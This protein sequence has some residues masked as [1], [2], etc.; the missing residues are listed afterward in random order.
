MAKKAKKVK[1]KGKSNH[2]KY[3]KVKNSIYDMVSSGELKIGDKAPSLVDM[4]DRFG[5]SRDTVILAYNNLKKEGV[6]RAVSGKGFFVENVVLDNKEKVFLLFDE[7][8]SFKETLYNSFIESVGDDAS[9]DLFFHNFSEKQ[10]NSLIED[11]KDRYSTYII[12]PSYFNNTREILETIESKNIIILDQIQPDLVEY[13]AIYQNFYADT[14]K[15]LV[16]G[17]NYIRKYS[18]LIMVHPG[19]K[20]PYGRVEAFESFCDQN[21]FDSEIID[22][23]DTREPD[24]GELYLIISDSDLVSLIKKLESS[25]YS[26]GEDVGIISYN[27]MPLKEIICGGITTI[28]TNFVTMGKRLGQ[29]VLKRDRVRI[30]NS[31]QLILRKSL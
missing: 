13:P 8:N 4:K 23:L 17:A 14:L 28:S 26:V 5:V 25:N 9:V 1:R 31:S 11:N 6:L 20:E 18:K 3:Q 22:S 21:R 12:M 27:D 24:K 30:E 16:Q 10:F 19:G 29:M 7:L 2:L 15:A